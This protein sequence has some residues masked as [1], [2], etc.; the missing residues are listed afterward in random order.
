[1]DVLVLSHNGS[2]VDVCSRVIR[3][4]LQNTKLAHITPLDNAAD[5]A[6]VSHDN[7]KTHRVEL[8]V[9]GDIRNAVEAVPFDYCPIIVTVLVLDQNILLVDAT[10]E[11]EACASCQVQVA[12]DSTGQVRGV[13]NQGSLS[14]S[15]YND[16]IATAMDASKKIFHQEMTL[17]TTTTSTIGVEHTNAQD[18][19]MTTSLLQTQYKF[20]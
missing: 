15:L 6:H 18:C 4:A 9:D 5:S 10:L 12:I 7:N 16:I 2:L 8:S 1:V 20:R 14:F 13:H 19:T 11:E 3:A 17:K